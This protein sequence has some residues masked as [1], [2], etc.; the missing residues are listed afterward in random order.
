MLS[1]EN[2]YIKLLDFLSDI[3]IYMML[4]ED[5]DNDKIIKLV[6]SS[7]HVLM[8]SFRSKSDELHKCS[9]DIKK[10]VRTGYNIKT[11]KEAAKKRRS[12]AVAAMAASGAKAIWK[13]S[14]SFGL[15][16]IPIQVFSATQKEEYFIQSTI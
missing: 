15:V 6:Q 2:Q 16:N 11:A 5:N 9:D 4:E 1:I 10:L 8:T 12:E 7:T 3:V 14:I 13:G